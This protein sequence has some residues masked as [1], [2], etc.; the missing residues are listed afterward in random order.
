MTIGR[1]SIP[2]AIQPNTRVLQII[3]RTDVH[4]WCVF[5]SKNNALVLYDNGRVERVELQPD[6]SE[7]I[8]LIKPED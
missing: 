2:I 7:R 4:A 5:L 8:G 1:A 3:R 6:G